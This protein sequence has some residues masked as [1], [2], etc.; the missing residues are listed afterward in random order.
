MGKTIW[1]LLVIAGI[2]AVGYF[3]FYRKSDNVGD[4]LKSTAENAMG[5]VETVAGGIADKGEG[6]MTK[7][8]E[9]AS[10]LKEGAGKA[11]ESASG[12]MAAKGQEALSS[13]EVT[14]EVGNKEEQL[15]SGGT[16]K[17]ER[18]ESVSGE[19][20]SQAKGQTEYV[21]EASEN[22]KAKGQESLDQGSQM[23]SD[24]KAK[25]GATGAQLSDLKDTGY[26]KKTAALR[27]DIAATADEKMET[28]DAKTA[29]INMTAK[30]A[31]AAAT[32]RGIEFES[33]S[34]IITTASKRTL[35]QLAK[36]LDQYPSIGIEVAGHT[37]AKGDAET[38]R[39]VSQ[40][41][42]DAVKDFLVK[43][44]VNAGRL[45]AVGYG[46][47]KPVAP[48]DTEMG[49]QQNRRVTIAAK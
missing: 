17:G 24:V 2:F 23:A 3:G 9:L 40:K 33:N 30:G 48:N 5:K 32:S 46:E 45:Q 43:S 26:G 34:T 37:D 35:Q 15:T 28:T 41:R 49:R 12:V 14:S 7:G 16:S 21:G 38:N 42:A 27:T 19:A 36:V 44:G 39:V 20:V 47:T 13:S 25:V 10:G 6:M 4:G 11:V 18:L 22:M 1:V 29:E 31:V 8:K